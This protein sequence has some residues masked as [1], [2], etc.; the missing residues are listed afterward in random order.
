[1]TSLCAGEPSALAPHANDS[2]C[3]RDRADVAGG[4]RSREGRPRQWP[5]GERETV[6]EEKMKRRGSEEKA[7]EKE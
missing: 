6:E 5:R 3:E 4:E 7:K 1:M 2:A